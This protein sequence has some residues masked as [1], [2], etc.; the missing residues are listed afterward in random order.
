MLPREE[1]WITDSCSRPMYQPE[2]R[3]GD[4][5]AGWI[6]EVIN[7]ALFR[8][9]GAPST[10]THVP[11]GQFAKPC[12]TQVHGLARLVGIREPQYSL[13]DRLEQVKDR[14]VDAVGYDGSSSICRG[15]S[16]QHLSPSNGHRGSRGRVELSITTTDRRIPNLLNKNPC[17]LLECSGVHFIIPMEFESVR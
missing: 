13:I 6:G 15:A 7:E 12:F 17:K 9:L 8:M 16:G 2:A 11:A 1:V 10:A 14:F 4:I 3:S 5:A